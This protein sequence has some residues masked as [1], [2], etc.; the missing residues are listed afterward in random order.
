MSKQY[1]PFCGK[2][3]VRFCAFV[4]FLLSAIYVICSLPIYAQTPIIDSLTAV[5]REREGMGSND[6]IMVNLLNKLSLEVRPSN[7]EQS[8]RYAKRAEEIATKISFPDGLALS[9]TNLGIALWKQGKL[10]PA[11]DLHTKALTLLK[12]RLSKI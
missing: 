11:L 1:T 2:S 9:C 12:L 5:L 10:A 4:S 7:V 3:A 8:F 6:T